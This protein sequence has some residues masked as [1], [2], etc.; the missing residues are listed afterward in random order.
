MLNLARVCFALIILWQPVWFVWLAPGQVLPLGLALAMLMLPLAACM[1]WV[2]HKRPG[3]LIL[4]GCLLLLH[5]SVAVMELWAS[6][7]AR[8]P[9][10]VQLL[11][12]LAYFAA[13]SIGLK[14]RN[15]QPGA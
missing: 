15:S 7:A 2:W 1:P 12:T 13:M 8:L 11:L 3:A 4:G 10:G 9:A 14:R 6:P 5:F